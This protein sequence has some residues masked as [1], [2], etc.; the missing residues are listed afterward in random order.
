MILS[1]VR[2]NKAGD[3]GFLKMRN[4]VN[5]LLSRAQHGMYILGNA[6]SLEANAQ[7]APM[8]SQVIGMLRE[9]GCMGKALQVRAAQSTATGTVAPTFRVWICWLHV[10]DAAG[11]QGTD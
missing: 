5:V 7:R 6:A 8:W 1:L 2:N 3:I 10:A 11:R 4:R 9:R